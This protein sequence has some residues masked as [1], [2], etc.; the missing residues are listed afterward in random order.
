M[1]R[2]IAD[3]LSPGIRKVF[4]N[5]IKSVNAQGLKKQESGEQSLNELWAE[6]SETLFINK[7]ID[8]NAAGIYWEVLKEN[9][10]VSA[11]HLLLR[12]FAI[13]LAND[14]RASDS[15]E[16]DAKWEARVPKV[17]D[18]AL[19]VLLA[20][21]VV[22]SWKDVNKYGGSRA[23][24]GALMKPLV[25]AVKT[26]LSRTAMPSK[27]SG[28]DSGSDSDSGSGSK[29]GSGSGSDS[30]KSPGS[31]SSF[32]SPGSMRAMMNDMPHAPS[33]PQDSS[34]DSSDAEGGKMETV[35]VPAD[36]F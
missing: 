26:A 3:L 36:L 16:K 15:G 8:D 35:D 19:E 21:L 24:P 9:V 23:A 14:A 11:L 34:P 1:E 13:S 5:I 12:R 2:A 33:P 17:E 32:D 10:D 7:R 28:S 25:A 30:P 20:M 31:P 27:E 6:I 18:F 29:S 22:M 4:S